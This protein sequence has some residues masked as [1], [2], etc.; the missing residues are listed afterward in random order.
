MIALID[1]GMGNLSSVRKA[2][3]AVGAKDIKLISTPQEIANAQAIVL[4]GVGN[5]GDG[6]KNL[7][8]SGLDTAIKNAVSDGKP[9]MGICL[10]MQL[11]MDSSEEA[12]NVKGLGIIKGKTVK[13]DSTFELKVPQIGWNSLS[14][15]KNHTCLQQIRDEEFFYF[16][17]SYYVV[18]ENQSYVAG[19]TQYGITF[20]SCIGKNNIFATQFH[21]EKSQDAGLQIIRNFVNSIQNKKLK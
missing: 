15:L 17:H 10:G 3:L 4:P 1:Y 18:P 13:F 11:L 16:V 12:P 14:I 9:F 21:P 5:F 19:T 2:F 7:I 6:A 8:E 20:C